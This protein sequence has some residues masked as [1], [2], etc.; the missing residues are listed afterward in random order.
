M[1]SQNWLCLG[2]SPNAKQ[3]LDRA[4]DLFGDDGLTFITCNHGINLIPCPDVYFITKDSYVAIQRDHSHL[5]KSAQDRGCCVATLKRC[6]FEGAHLVVNDTSREGRT[7]DVPQRG[8]YSRFR[9]SGTFMIQ[10]ACNLG[11][12]RL[13]LAGFEGYYEGRPTHFNNEWFQRRDGGDYDVANQRKYGREVVEAMIP[14][15]VREWDD[16]EFIHIGPTRYP[17]DLPNW[18]NRPL[19]DLK[20]EMFYD[21]RTG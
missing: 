13:I 9:N 17:V 7:I 15:I 8:G 11:A 20:G 16:V 14:K 6:Q 3:G 10:L 1:K 18:S 2:S 4:I 19:T 21:R 12:K 5:I